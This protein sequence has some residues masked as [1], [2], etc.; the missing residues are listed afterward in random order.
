L[1]FNEGVK[2]VVSAIWGNA[3]KKPRVG[4]KKSA[5]FPASENAVCCRHRPLKVKGND[6][7]LRVA[8]AASGILAELFVILSP[9]DKILNLLH[10]YSKH[11]DDCNH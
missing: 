8:I 6:D 3:A 1:G 5:G 7:G 9:K 2:S 11:I 4:S 10:A